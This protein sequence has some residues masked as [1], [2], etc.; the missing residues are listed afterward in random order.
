[1]SGGEVQG[2]V[3]ESIRREEGLQC[4]LARGG[5]REGEGPQVS[6]EAREAL[7]SQAMPRMHPCTGMACVCRRAIDL[8]AVNEA[9]T[10][11]LANTT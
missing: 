1:M 6:D 10:V 3:P 8:L 11:G 5:V 7:G 9:C 2:S 4:S